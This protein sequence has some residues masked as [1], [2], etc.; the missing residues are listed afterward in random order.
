MSNSSAIKSQILALLG[1]QRIRLTPS[2]LERQLVRYRL[3]PC[4]RIIRSLIKEMVAEGSLLYTNHFNT[5][6]LEVNY[7]RPFQVSD[8]IILSQQTCSSTNSNPNAVFINIDQGC[9]FGIG[10]HPTTRLSLRGID[11]VMQEA[12]KRGSFDGFQALD[13]GTGS[14]VLAMAAVGLGA[15]SAVGIDIDQSAL[16]EAGRNIRMNGMDQ[17]IILTTDSLESLVESRFSLVMANLRPPTLKQII[18]QIEKVSKPEAYWVFSGCRE[19]GLES[20]TAMLPST[21]T[22]IFW[23]EKSCGWAALAVKYERKSAR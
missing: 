14:G 15:A 1:N 18:F 5:T 3:Q 23:K 13:I 19:E 17:K 6:H 20:V 12:S 11:L 4:K 10:D 8:R 2:A 16:Y 7:N 9:A 21:K 22:R